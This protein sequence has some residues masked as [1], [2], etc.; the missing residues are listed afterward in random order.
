MLVY[1]R[2]A[3]VVGVLGRHVLH[4]RSAAAA[5]AAVAAAAALLY[6]ET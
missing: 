1:L 2:M 4:S 6:G 3:T 5:A